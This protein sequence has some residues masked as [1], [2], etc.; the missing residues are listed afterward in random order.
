MLRLQKFQGG[1]MHEDD[2]FQGIMESEA[3]GGGVVSEDTTTISS[4]EHYAVRTSGSTGRGGRGDS[5]R[6]PAHGAQFKGHTQQMKQGGGQQL[7]RDS[8]RAH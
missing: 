5:G 2:D 1:E 6:I 3:L 8:R 7:Q 4:G